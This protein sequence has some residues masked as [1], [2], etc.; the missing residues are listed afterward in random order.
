M[1]AKVL[2]F[3]AGQAATTD[4]QAEID[5]LN[6]AARPYDI[7]LRSAAASSL[8]GEKLE[9]CDFVAGTIPTAY[10]EVATIDPD[11]IPAIVLT[12]EQVVVNDGDVLDT[13]D[14]GTVTVAVVDGV[15]T[16]TYAAGA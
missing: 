3:T 2:Y 15:A 12:D 16:Y 1:T 10:E 13:E 7:Q 6:A 11:N 5:A 14:G 9:D 8:Y 4:E